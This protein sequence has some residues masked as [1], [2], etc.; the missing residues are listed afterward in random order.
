[1]GNVCVWQGK[2]KRSPATDFP[3]SPHRVWVNL[4]AERGETRFKGVG[5]GNLYLFGK[6][7]EKWGLR[8]EIGV[9]S[10]RV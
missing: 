7:R 2:K 5:K 4:G 9:R 10:V 1:V 8:T 3:L 6:D